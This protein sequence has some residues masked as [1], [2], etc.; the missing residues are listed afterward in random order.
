VIVCALLYEGIT[1]EID[2]ISNLEL[3]GNISE[4]A[5]ILIFCWDLYTVVK[6]WKSVEQNNA[7]DF[8]E[9]NE[10]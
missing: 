6:N 5:Y 4:M 8:V 2:G 3:L 9:Q 10:A 7:I 1:I